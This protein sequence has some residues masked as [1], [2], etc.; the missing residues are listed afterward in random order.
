MF[1]YEKILYGIVQLKLHAKIIR[2]RKGK[3]EIRQVE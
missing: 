1:V 3:I 2:D